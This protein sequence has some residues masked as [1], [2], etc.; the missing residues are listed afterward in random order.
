MTRK[1]R[2]LHRAQRCYFLLVE[3]KSQLAAYPELSYA[4]TLIGSLMDK[5]SEEV[6]ICENAVN[7]QYTLAS[8]LGAEPDE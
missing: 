4:S 8:R 7:E 1:E 2:I 5:I 3:A 6:E